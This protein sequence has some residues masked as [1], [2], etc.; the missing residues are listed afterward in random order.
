M[1]R[2]LTV[3]ALSA[4]LGLSTMGFKTSEAITSECEASTDLSVATSV[5]LDKEAGDGELTGKIVNSSDNNDYDEIMV[6]LDFYGADGALMGTDET[7][8]GDTDIKTDLNNSATMQNDTD[9]DVDVDA[10]LEDGELDADI[11]SEAA[12]ETDLNDSGSLSEGSNHS[13]TSAP[14][15][16]QVVTINEDVEAG[17]VEEFEIDVTPPAGATR[18]V[19]TVVCAD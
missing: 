5:D 12:A 7:E 2:I 17:E 16:S 8:I 10:D 9:L 3:V 13:A 18:V 11:D 4:A 14:L 19:A 6:R 15:H 1:K